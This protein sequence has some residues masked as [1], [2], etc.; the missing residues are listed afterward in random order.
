M[1]KYQTNFFFVFQ[2]LRENS[3]ILLQILFPFQILFKKQPNLNP[4]ED[5]H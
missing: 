3:K 1:N 4:V 5:L 2:F